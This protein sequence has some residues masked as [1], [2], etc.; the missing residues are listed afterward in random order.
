MAH[1]LWRLENGQ[2]PKQPVKLFVILIGTN[3]LGAAGCV[4]PTTDR[5]E[6]EAAGV[7]SRY[8]TSLS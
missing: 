1:L 7:I 6:K 2:L 8:R 4:G 5:L 3:D